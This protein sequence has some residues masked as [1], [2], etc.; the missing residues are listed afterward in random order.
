MLVI[1]AKNCNEKKD[2]VVDCKYP[3]VKIRF[4]YINKYESNKKWY[5]DSEG[6]DFYV[7]IKRMDY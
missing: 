7:I 6:F 3:C 5:I 1:I 4:K 2:L